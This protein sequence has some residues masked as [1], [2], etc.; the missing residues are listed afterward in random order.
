MRI[1]VVKVPLCCAVRKSPYHILLQ[2]KENTSVTKSEV[3]KKFIRVQEFLLTKSF[4]HES[5]NYFS[6]ILHGN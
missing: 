5:I 6:A 1:F 4:F 2:I 3:V